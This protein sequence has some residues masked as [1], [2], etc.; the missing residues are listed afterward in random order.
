MNYRL[1]AKHS[2]TSDNHSLY[3]LSPKTGHCRTSKNIQTTFPPKSPSRKTPTPKYANKVRPIRE[4]CPRL[5]IKIYILIIVRCL[6]GI[7]F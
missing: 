6:V 2:R 4:N 5:Y 1:N 3:E 7:A